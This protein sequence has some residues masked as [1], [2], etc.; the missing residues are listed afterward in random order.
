ML[1]L[2][3][4]A[5]LMLRRVRPPQCS[6]CG[7][8][9]AK[10]RRLLSGP[11]VYLCEACIRDASERLAEAEVG[12]GAP[13]RCRFCGVTRPRAPLGGGAAPLVVCAPC[14]RLMEGML[15]EHDARRGAAT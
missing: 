10:A 5:R 7:Q 3:D 13:G 4:A 15:A 6:A 11:G 9:K 14:V 1:H 2:R 12:T 8:P